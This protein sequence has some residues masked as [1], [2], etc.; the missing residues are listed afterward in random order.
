MSTVEGIAA[1]CI[2]IVHDSGGQREVVP[3]DELRFRDERGAEER[4][5]AALE[6]RFDSLLDG[7]QSHIAAFNT[8]AF[9]RRMGALLDDALSPRALELAA[10]DVG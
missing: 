4:I 7:L 8:R 2:P 1:G 10:S 9:D 6:G 3:N 5:R